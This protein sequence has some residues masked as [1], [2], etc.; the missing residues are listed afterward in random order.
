LRAKPEE[1]AYLI[2]DLAVQFA[3]CGYTTDALGLVSKLNRYS[4][5]FRDKASA[6][7]KAVTFPLAGTGAV[8]GW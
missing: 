7:L 3:L 5:S 8:A 6:P 1:L 4:R 2:A